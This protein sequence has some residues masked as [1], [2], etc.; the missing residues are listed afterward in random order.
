MEEHKLQPFEN[1]VLRKVFGPKRDEITK[2]WRRLYNEQL[3]ALY[4]SVVIRM[5]KSKRSC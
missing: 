4:S 1:Q 2:E 5:V 3:Y